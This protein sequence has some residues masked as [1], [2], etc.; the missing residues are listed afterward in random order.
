MPYRFCCSSPQCAGMGL[1]NIVDVGAGQSGTGANELILGT[2]NSDAL[3]QGGAGNDCI[4]GGGGDN[5]FFFIFG[6]LE[7]GDGDDVIIGGPGKDHCDGGD[8]TDTYIGC[9]T[10]NN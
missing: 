4:L 6:G 8:G 5:R 7:G 2:A 1:T 10:T 9:E 3:I